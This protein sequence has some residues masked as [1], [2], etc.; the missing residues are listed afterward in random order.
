MKKVLGLLLCG[1][2]LAAVPI[3]APGQSL[4]SGSGSGIAFF[5]AAHLKRG[6]NLSM[7]YAQTSDYSAV[8][9]ES[10]TTA[11]DFRLVKRL[12]FDH[13]RLSINPEPLML[14]G[15]VDMLDLAAIARLDNT[16]A[17]ITGTG[18][19]VI[20]DIHPEMPFVEDLGQGNNPVTR[21]LKFWTVFA[22]HFAQTDPNQVY[23][24]ILNEPHMED[25]YR[26]A[27]IQSKVVPAIR[28]VAPKHT[29]IATGNHWGGVD[30][31]LE[32]EPVRD[33]NVIYSFHDYDP[34]TFTHQG[35]TWSTG[36]LKT[37]RGVPYPSSPQSVA[38]LAAAATDDEAKRQ[39]TKYG[40]EQ[41]DAKRVDAEIATA[42]AWGIEHRVPV[43][44]GEFGVYRNYAEPA[45]RAEWLH[46]MRVAFE[47]HGIG[48]SMWDYQGSFALVTNANGKKV[49]DA[50]VAAALG[51]NAPVE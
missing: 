41:W 7:W 51:L 36:Y 38:A 8:R 40:A 44:C 24:E 10:Y 4:G 25:S 46:D 30:G 43:W 9:L 18:L 37:L 17:E 31:L 13:V 22:E 12:G 21:F 42:A 27:G 33:P 16:V 32:L 48:W 35:A 34:M 1:L 19:I 23:F 11:E 2:T 39:L 15:R 29:I 47:A 14:G 45:A 49:V 26:W 20:L 6:I 28:A 3:P 5:R 50:P